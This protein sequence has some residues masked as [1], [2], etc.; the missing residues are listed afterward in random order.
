MTKVRR[1]AEGNANRLIDE[2]IHPHFKEHPAFILLDGF[3]H[4]MVEQNAEE[5]FR[6][7]LKY[8]APK[9]PGYLISKRKRPNRTHR[10]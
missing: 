6:K 8:N 3:L 2:L 1:T 4:A 7:F 9:L 5:S 10:H